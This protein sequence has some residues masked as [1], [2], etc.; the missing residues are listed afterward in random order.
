MRAL[1]PLA[2][3]ADGGRQYRGT[4][5]FNRHKQGILAERRIVG[6]SL[7]LVGDTDKVK[8]Y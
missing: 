1:E 3:W 7:D 2:R 8:I 4:L 6:V 5:R